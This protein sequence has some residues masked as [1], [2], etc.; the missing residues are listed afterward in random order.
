MELGSGYLNLTVEE[1]ARI[2][3]VSVYAVID[4]CDLLDRKDRI[5]REIRIVRVSDFV[6]M[7]EECRK[8]AVEGYTF[9]RNV[10]V[11]TSTQLSSFSS[12][13]YA[14][15]RAIVLGEDEP[16]QASHVEMQIR[17]ATKNVAVVRTLTTTLLFSARTL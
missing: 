15:V 5:K 9:P 12:I 8:K 1:K 4:F 11:G 2:V 7:R 16:D 14:R 6:E 17:D 13:P 10:F 3:K